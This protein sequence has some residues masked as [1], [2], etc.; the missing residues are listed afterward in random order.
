MDQATKVTY[1]FIF[2]SLTVEA[3]I[4]GDHTPQGFADVNTCGKKAS[5]SGVKGA[6][7]AIFTGFYLNWY[8]LSDKDK[9]SISD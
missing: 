4:L 7:G 1:D 6:S 2:S 3:T 5:Y 9:Q 8:N